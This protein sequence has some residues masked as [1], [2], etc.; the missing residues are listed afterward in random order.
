MVEAV[1]DKKGSDIVVLDIRSISLLAD[2]FVIASSVTE[3]QTKA[4]LEEVVSTMKEVGSP[5]LHIEG[6]PNSGWVLVDHGDVIVHLF[7]PEVRQY[8][9]L[10]ELW[11]EAKVVV[12][13]Q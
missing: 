10:E 3:R 8:Y 5:P 4:I 2:Y 7:T 12:K 13:I 9:Q 1:A 6:E 11:S